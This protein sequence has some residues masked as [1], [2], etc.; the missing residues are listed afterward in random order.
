MPSH[1][2]QKEEAGA[3]ARMPL[4]VGGKIALTHSNSATF[5]RMLLTQLSSFFLDSGMRGAWKDA[6]CKAV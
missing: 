4:P 5:R 3:G 6:T 2:A 1:P